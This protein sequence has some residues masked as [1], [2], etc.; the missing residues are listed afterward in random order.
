MPHVDEIH[1]F[2]RRHTGLL[3]LRNEME[4]RIVAITRTVPID[5]SLVAIFLCLIQYDV[6]LVLLSRERQSHFAFYP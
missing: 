3:L 1:F 4:T 6:Q 5:V 2:Q